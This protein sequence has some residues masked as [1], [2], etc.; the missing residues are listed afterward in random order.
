MCGPEKSSERAGK[1]G[2]QMAQEDTSERRSLL[3]GEGEMMFERV[4]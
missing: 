3:W 1:T 4:G 2:K